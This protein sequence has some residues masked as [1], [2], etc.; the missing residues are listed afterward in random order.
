M[1]LRILKDNKECKFVLLKHGAANI[2]LFGKAETDQMAATQVL[3][4]NIRGVPSHFMGVHF[5][6]FGKEEDNG[7]VIFYVHQTDA[8]LAEFTRAAAYGIFQNA[9]GPITCTTMRHSSS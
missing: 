5:S 8:T 3:S 2:N 1:K 9:K 4:G 7:Y 6:G